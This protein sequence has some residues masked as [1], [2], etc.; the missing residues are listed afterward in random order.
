MTRRVSILGITLGLNFTWVGNPAPPNPTRPEARTGRCKF[1][2]RLGIKGTKAGRV[3]LSLIGSNHN[4]LGT[5]GIGGKKLSDFG[6]GAGNA[7]MNRG[8]KVLAAVPYNVSNLYMVSYFY[9]RFT[10]PANMLH[11]GK[12]YLFRGRQQLGLAVGG[13]LMMRQLRTAKAPF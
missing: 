9:S 5:D 10:G 2:R 1:L 7:G 11:H 13:S 4:C 8:G 6:D 12:D 3:G